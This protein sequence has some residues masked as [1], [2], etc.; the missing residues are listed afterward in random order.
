MKPTF[1]FDLEAFELGN[2][3]VDAL[4]ENL[5]QLV[6]FDP[7]GLPDLLNVL[8]VFIILLAD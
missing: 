5:P 8:W 6:L 1:D 4:I 7:D 3:L 2:G